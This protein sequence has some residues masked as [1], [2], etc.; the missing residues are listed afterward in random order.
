MAYE[1]CIHAARR[2]P[3]RITS[4][5]APARALAPP[6]RRYAHEALSQQVQSCAASLQGVTVL[7]HDASASSRHSCRLRFPHGA[8]LACTVV[9]WTQ[10]GCLRSQYRASMLPGFAMSVISVRAAA[11]VMRVCGQIGQLH[12]IYGPEV[13][14]SSLSELALAEQHMTSHASCE[15]C[16]R[17]CCHVNQPGSDYGMS[18]GTADVVTFIC[19]Y[20]ATLTSGCTGPSAFALIL[21]YDMHSSVC[22]CPAHVCG[23]AVFSPAYSLY[24]LSCSLRTDNTASLK[25]TPLLHFC[26]RYP[27]LKASP[28]SK[29]YPS[30]HDQSVLQTSAAHPWWMMYLNNMSASVGRCHPTPLKPG[31]PPGGS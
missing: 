19:C 26:L 16:A 27:P 9:M 15:S 3:T 13:P 7:I 10:L 20:D 30:P 11:A 12:Q 18:V 22:V 4:A 31:P 23:A 29:A 2:A 17:G 25:V 1:A 5:A 24:L 14:V 28:S 6:S 21:G 8:C